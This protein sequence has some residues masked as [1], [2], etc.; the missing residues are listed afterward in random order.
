M[1]SHECSPATSS[2][3]LVLLLVV[4]VVVV[5]ASDLHCCAQSHPLQP[6]RDQKTQ[7]NKLN[8]TAHTITIPGL[9]PQVPGWGCVPVNG[10]KGGLA[11]RDAEREREI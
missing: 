2:L 11:W 9:D 7:L 6:I 4:V 3:G 10:I 1:A 8:F 5:G